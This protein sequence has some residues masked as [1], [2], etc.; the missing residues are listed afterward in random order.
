ME[1]AGLGVEELRRI[2]AAMDENSP[3]RLEESLLPVCPGSA[4]STGP[5]ESVAAPIGLDE[6]AERSHLLQLTDTQ[7]GGG[8]LEFCYTIRATGNSVHP[9]R[10]SR[11]RMTR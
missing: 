5:A 7:A 9:T 1:P 11:S 10:R 4:L 3:R 8:V 2:P 6:A